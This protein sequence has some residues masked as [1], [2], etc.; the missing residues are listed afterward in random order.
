MTVKS[1]NENIN[2][3]RFFVYFYFY[4][5]WRRVSGMVVK[6]VQ[7]LRIKNCKKKVLLEN[8]IRVP[9]T[10]KRR[11]FP[12][13][14]IFRPVDN[15]FSASRNHRGGNV[16]RSARRP[17]V[18]PTRSV[19][20][21][22]TRIGRR[23]VTKKRG[24]RTDIKYKI[25]IPE[26][27]AAC[28]RFF[29]FG[30]ALPENRIP[31]IFHRDDPGFECDQFSTPVREA[32]ARFE[33]ASENRVFLLL[34]GAPFRAWSPGPRARRVRLARGLG[35]RSRRVA[36]VFWRNVTRVPCT[37]GGRDVVYAFVSTTPTRALPVFCSYDVREVIH[38]YSVRSN[39]YWHL[40]E[41]DRTTW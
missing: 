26:R 35:N 5:F 18:Y 10:W 25:I 38:T 32:P 11:A 22:R 6:N 39:L 40:F 36:R 29:F 9:H 37:R 41:V 2:C 15:A 14:G 20:S 4:F 19:L 33:K 30:R 3:R 13:R 16:I 27:T 21:C 24:E 1:S 17:T 31:R 28:R 12:F 23:R 7:I 8:S 34:G